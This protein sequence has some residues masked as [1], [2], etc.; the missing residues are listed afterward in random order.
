MQRYS[1]SVSGDVYDRVRTAVQ[2]SLSAFVDEIVLKALNDPA[3]LARL[4][5]RCQQKP[6]KVALP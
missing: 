6:P 4:V 2:G 5:P 3:T 1:I